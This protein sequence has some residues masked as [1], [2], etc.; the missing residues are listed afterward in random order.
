MSVS[1]RDDRFA[2]EAAPSPT[3]ALRA[4]P[5]P[6]VEPDASA[7]HADPDVWRPATWGAIAGFVVGTLLVA[8]G[9]MAVG[10]EIG[11][12]LALGTFVGAF[13]GAGFGFMVGASILLARADSKASSTHRH[14]KP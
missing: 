2:A 9:G 10:L 4:V 8:A 3:S 6:D 13:G 12:A 5:A 7:V 11:S 1:A 14:P